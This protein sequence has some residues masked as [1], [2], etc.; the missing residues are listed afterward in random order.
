VR[1]TTFVS[2]EGT[3]R[4]CTPLRLPKKYNKGKLEIQQSFG[5][6]GR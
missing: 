3:N 1:G 2:V 6:W 4:K 5:E